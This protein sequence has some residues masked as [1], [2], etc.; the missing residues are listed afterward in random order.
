[1]VLPPSKDS[2]K[3]ALAKEIAVDLFAAAARIAGMGSP[4]AIIDAA[5]RSV[6]VTPF[7]LALV[8]TRDQVEFQRV[9]LSG[10]GPGARRLRRLAAALAIE[11]PPQLERIRRFH[12]SRPSSINTRCVR[13]VGPGGGAFLVLAADDAGYRRE[14]PIDAP[15]TTDPQRPGAMPLEIGAP[16]RSRFLWRMDKDGRFGDPHPVLAAALGDHAPKSGETIDHVR[17]RAAVENGPA[18]AAATEKGETFSGL[19]VL[20]RVGDGVRARPITFSGT[21]IFDKGREYKGFTGFGT[22]GEAL[23][24]G[25]E[26]PATNPPAT[27]AKAEPEHKAATVESGPVHGSTER[28]SEGSATPSEPDKAD[29]PA[30]RPALELDPPSDRLPAETRS[31]EIYVF[32]HGQSALPAAS[33]IVPIRPGAFDMSR[34]PQEAGETAD[35]SVELSRAERE[36]FREIARA[37]VG[38]AHAPRQD[39]TESASDG[40]AEERERSRETLGAPVPSP[41]SDQGPPPPADLIAG[42]TLRNALAL[43]DRVSVGVLVADETR[44]LYVNLTLLALLGYRD[45]EQ[46]EALN[47]LSAMFRGDARPAM[48]DNDARRDLRLHDRGPGTG[49]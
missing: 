19:T 20:W 43:L 45:R 29:E 38:R 40:P 2:A 34:P 10:D 14:D 12:G 41:S 35:G 23:A 30:S 21:P 49:R 16:L 37:L 15:E 46:F 18:L 7:G 1:M 4:I 42:P 22:V 28:S 13:I 8:G 32:R 47:G 5:G 31:A 25:G 17:L 33:K 39:E 24:V 27:D 44:A 9:F 6:A 3:I 48:S 26:I 11:D 36:A